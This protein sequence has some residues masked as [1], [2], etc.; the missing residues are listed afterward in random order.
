MKKFISILALCII[1]AMMLQFSICVF[2]EPEDGHSLSDVHLSLTGE[3]VLAYYTD[4]FD[5]DGNDEAFALI[6]DKRSEGTELLYEAE[7]WFIKGDHSSKI[8]DSKFYGTDGK[9]V[10]FNDREFLLLNEKYAAGETAYLWGVENGEPKLQNIS[11]YGG[12]LKRTGEN[13]IV[14]T[15]SAYDLEE[16][17]GV[18]AGHTRKEYYFWFERENNCFCEYGA[19]NITEEQLAM[20]RNAEGYIEQINNIGYSI[21]DILYRAN[22]IININYSDG[23]VNRNMTL[24]LKNNTVYLVPHCDYGSNDLELSDQGGI[25][26]DAMI[27]EIAVYPDAFPS[28]SESDGTKVPDDDVMNSEENEDEA[29]S[30]RNKIIILVTFALLAVIALLEL[31]VIITVTRRKNADKNEGD[32]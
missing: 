16:S 12:N 17:N 4:D 24:L 14:L 1:G 28:I 30:G 11:G 6:G 27:P 10:R 15:Q 8:T 2:A 26:L 29:G 13:D 5:G 3:N 23:S 20:C 9:I 21:T 31:V 25:Y 32:S 7:V 18:M 22:G 19:I